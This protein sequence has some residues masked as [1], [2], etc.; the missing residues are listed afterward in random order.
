MPTFHCQRNTRWHG[1]NTIVNESKI[2]VAKLH[3]IYQSEYTQIVSWLVNTLYV[4]YSCATASHLHI[5]P[6]WRKK[7]KISYLTFEKQSFF[8]KTPMVTMIPK[9]VHGWTDSGSSKKED[10]C[11]LKHFFCT[12]HPGE[13]QVAGCG[14]I[15]QYE[16]EKYV[17]DHCQSY[18]QAM[19]TA[20]KGKLIFQLLLCPGNR[21]LKSFR[22]VYSTHSLSIYNKVL[23]LPETS[24]KHRLP[25]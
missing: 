22:V 17:N 12:F 18:I 9:K 7:I 6:I 16:G 8:I 1:K 21:I 24:L 2:Y 4:P 25:Y 14:A 19:N 13:L 15:V 20:K 10:Y 5:H 23:I 11:I 3:S